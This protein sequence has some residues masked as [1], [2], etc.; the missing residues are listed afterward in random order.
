MMA[1]CR[2]SAYDDC[3]DDHRS[4]RNETIDDGLT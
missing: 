3:M 2:F 1:S 4:K